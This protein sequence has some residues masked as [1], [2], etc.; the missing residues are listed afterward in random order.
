MII[1]PH[2]SQA[3]EEGLLAVGGNL[4]PQTLLAAYARGIFPW[5]AEGQPILWWS[6]DP[7]M[8]LFPD[9]FHCS[10]RL[11]RRLKQVRY[12]FSRNEAFA[13]VINLCANIPRK[14]EQG[15]W[16]LPEMKE[17]Y[18]R[19]HELGFAHSVEVWEGGSLIGGVYGV[20]TE[21][22]FFAE[23]MFSLKTDASKMALAHLVALAK[24]ENW[25]VI[26][27]QFHTD[28][29]ASLGAREIPR[30]RFLDLI[31]GVRGD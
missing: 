29:L 31:N 5:Y 10:R 12:R 9:E 17:A 24:A 7:R 30:Q 27:S 1:F 3:N 22:V 2:P 19:L 28:H 4:Q 25:K 26:D 23:S 20:L 16:I 11:S 8:V 6:P 15:T 21:R 14:G 13:D 18:L